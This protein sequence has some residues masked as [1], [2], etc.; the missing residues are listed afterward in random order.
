[1]E[2]DLVPLPKR[3]GRASQPQDRVGDIPVLTDYEVK[4]VLRSIRAPGYQVD[5]GC[6]ST[7]TLISYVLLVSWGISEN[8]RIGCAINA[9]N[10]I[11][12]KMDRI[13]DLQL[14]EFIFVYSSFPSLSERPEDRQPTM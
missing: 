8:R 5:S 11:L 3:F 7:L 12:G 2:E 6:S 9:L 4:R 13:V 10:S 14:K 1:M